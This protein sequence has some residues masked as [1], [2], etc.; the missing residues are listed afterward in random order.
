MVTMFDHRAASIVLNVGNAVRPQQSAPLSIQEHLSA[1]TRVLPYLWASEEDAAERAPGEWCYRWFATLKRVTASTNERMFIGCVTPWSAVS[2]TLYVITC[3]G[4][5]SSLASLLSLFCSF[6]ADYLVRQKTSQPS[7]PIGPIL[8]TAI[9]GPSAFLSESL[10]TSSPLA[11]WLQERVLELT[12]TSSDL[13]PF[14]RDCGWDGPPFRWDEERR[15]RI[16][17]ELDATFFHLYLSA[18][19]AGHWRIARKADGCPQDETAGELAELAR[20]F[21]TPRDAVAYIM[22]TFPIV[23]RKD[24]QKYNGDYRTKRV[25][26]EIYDAMQ[27]AI[28]TGQP[29]QTRL[30][31]PPGPPRDADG[32]F[33][34]YAQIADSL[35]PHIHL[36]RNAAEGGS[37]A[38]QMSD[39]A[40][41]FPSAPFL[42]R[43]GT[44]GNAKALRVR[45]VR[46]AEIQP[47]DRVVL[48]SA[49]LRSAGNT[50]PAAFGRLR[51]EGRIDASDGSAYLLVTVRSDDGTA[52][53]RFSEEEWR[54]LTTVGVVDES[55]G[56]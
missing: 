25:T 23:R 17:C 22:D 20:H 34:P 21:P 4:R 42:L 35:P 13:G 11:G 46:T 49:K 9:I 3:K 24:E 5:P 29:Y 45:P 8:E 30:D 32:N 48:A 38:L 18:D 15:F 7:L 53:A 54:G 19:A 31:P 51:F 16:R 1:E 50:V 37:V 47:A 28:R 56:S 12:Y 6:A 26:L 36:P 14:A 55:D 52:H 41:R 40:F 2:Y 44:S 33:V 10:V 43:L 39:L 27:E